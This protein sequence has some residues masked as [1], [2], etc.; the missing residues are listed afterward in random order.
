MKRIPLTSNFF[1][2]EVLDPHTY[3]TN[4]DAGHTWAVKIAPAL[5]LFRNTIGR[6]CTVNNWWNE[7]RRLKEE[8]KSDVQIIASIEQNNSLRKW[9]GSRTDYCT[10]GAGTSAHKLSKNEGAVDIVSNG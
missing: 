7:Y 8:G 5:Q 9:A 2:D 1:L 6:P 4:R 3:M 10:V